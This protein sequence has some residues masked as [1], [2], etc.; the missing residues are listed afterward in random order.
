MSDYVQ[1]PG[2]DLLVSRVALG[3]CP[4]GGY[5]W[6]EV[7]D[8][9]AIAAVRRAEACGVNFFDTADVYGL[10]HSEELLSLALGECRTE[11][12]IASK[13]GVRRT[14]DGRT[15]KDISPAYLRR[16]L[17][18]SLRRLRLDCIPLYYIHWPD[19]KT[20]VE[21]AVLEL[22]RCRQAGKIR[23]IGVSNFSADE[24]RRACRV[25][26]ISALQVQYSLVDRHVVAPLSQAVRECQVPLITWGSL[27]QG[28]LTGKYSAGATFG[29]NDRRRGYENFRGAKWESNLRT[30]DE[31]HVLADRLQ[32]TP[33]Q[34][35]LR[36]LL[37]TP[38]V[39][40]VLCG[41][42]SPDQIEENWGALGW[43][44]SAADYQLLA[45]LPTEAAPQAA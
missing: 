5:G 33:G 27:A 34:I 35:A 26:R 44:L 39:A 3:G 11:V 15:V 14:P 18:A 38:G 13:F 28:L 7:D 31:L 25:A 22:E 32:R 2:C 37:D 20:P 8:A 41:A 45:S 1:L 21:D 10:G 17:E 40:T 36:W 42:K 12:V 9:Q 30:V 6:G 29:S 19:G 4:L 16:A 23:A 24:L 43:R